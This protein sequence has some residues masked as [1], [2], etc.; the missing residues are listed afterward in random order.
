VRTDTYVSIETLLYDLRRNQLVWAGQSRTMNPQD[1]DIFIAELVTAV[2][3]EL[4]EA[5][6]LEEK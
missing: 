4:R 2:A 1:V 6:L 3:D 5:G